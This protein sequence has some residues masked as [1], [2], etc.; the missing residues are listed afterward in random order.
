[1]VKYRKISLHTVW[2]IYGTY[3]SDTM[4]IPYT[5]FAVEVLEVPHG[6]VLRSSCGNWTLG[7]TNI[8]VENPS[9]ISTSIA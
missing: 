7:E 2:E 1:M 4:G 6:E 9:R 8:D 3:H 5:P